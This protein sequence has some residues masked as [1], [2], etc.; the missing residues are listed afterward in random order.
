MSRRMD[1]PHDERPAQRR[2]LARDVPAEPRQDQHQIIQET[3]LQQCMGLDGIMG[4]ILSCLDVSDVVRSQRVNQRWKGLGEKATLPKKDFQDGD[5]LRE[6]AKKY[7][8]GKEGKN[9][10]GRTYGY[11]INTWRVGHVEDF[12]SVFKGQATFNECIGDWDMSSAKTTAHMFCGARSF[13]QDLSQW[14]TSQVKDMQGMFRAARAFNKPL[15]TWDTSRVKNMSCMF[16]FAECFNQSLNTWDTSHVKNMSSMFKDTHDFNK[17]LDSWDTSQVRD[18][19]NMFHNAA[20]FDQPLDSWDTSQVV[21]MSRMFYRAS[22][23]KNLGG[24]NTDS[25]VEYG[26]FVAKTNFWGELP[27]GMDRDVAFGR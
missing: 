24:W 9:E 22:F 26:D 27:P 21:D 10:V 17:E 8:D 3:L 13:N 12:D 16:V 14:T 5:E 7:C 15:N 6:A 25:L 19:S 2:R 11:P 1:P 20:W 23:K 4:H 18:M